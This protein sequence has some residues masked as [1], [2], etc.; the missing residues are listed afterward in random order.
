MKTVRRGR[1]KFAEKRGEM[2][3]KTFKLN[4]WIW[5]GNWA[6]KKNKKR[7]WA[8][9]KPFLLREKRLLRPLLNNVALLLQLLLL[10]ICSGFFFLQLHQ[11]NGMF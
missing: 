7:L 10:K 9:K 11:G 6:G 3:Q 5:K 4:L 2:E 1:F 8:Y